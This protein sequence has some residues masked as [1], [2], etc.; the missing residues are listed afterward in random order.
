MTPSNSATA[1]PATLDEST[2][3]PVRQSGNM[4]AVL[5]L[6]LRFT[7]GKLSRLIWQTTTA[8]I[9]MA[10]P[11]RV[12]T[13]HGLPTWLL[14]RLTPSGCMTCT[15]MFGSGAWIAGTTITRAHRLTVVLG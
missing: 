2:V 14:F 8:T 5:V 1:F 9:P 7:L 12:F 3:C 15:A 6:T 4:P 13:E 11:K 10:V